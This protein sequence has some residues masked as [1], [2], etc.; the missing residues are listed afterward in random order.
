MYPV[1]FHIYGPLAINSYGVAIVIGLSIFLWLAN[2]NP[3]RAKLMSEDTFQKFITYGIIVAI[4]G[5]RLLHVI[6]EWSEYQNWFEMINI[7]DGGFSILG[8]VVALIMYTGLFLTKNKIPVL[9]TF[10]LLAQYAPIVQAF[11]RIGCFLAGCCYGAAT[12][13]LLGVTYTNPLTAAPL[14]IKIHPTQLYSAATFFIIFFILQYIKP[15]LV[16]PGQMFS[17]YLILSSLERF[18]ID[19]WRN[20]RIIDGAY[21]SL[22]NTHYFSLHQWIALSL[23][24]VGCISLYTCSRT[25]SPRHYSL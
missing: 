12:T 10:D 24:L 22:I 17:I 11:G 1:L 2:K 21:G 3:L 5:G 23:V 9:P 6:S 7:L 20:D 8:T 14:G 16:K 13:C 18:I 4:V 19:F 15:R 25:K